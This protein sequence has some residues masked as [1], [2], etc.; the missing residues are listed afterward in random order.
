MPR[1]IRNCLSRNDYPAIRAAAGQLLSTGHIS[2][3]L[4]ATYSRVIVDEFQDCN[5]AQHVIFAWLG[6]ALPTYVLDD[7]MQAIFG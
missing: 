2:G 4:K 7:P 5:Q 1:E 6:R 3:V